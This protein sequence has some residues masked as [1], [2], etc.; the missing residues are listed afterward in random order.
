M[1]Y[2]YGLGAVVLTMEPTRYEHGEGYE[3]GDS[4]RQLLDQGPGLLT[5]QT[6]LRTPFVW[7]QVRPPNSLPSRS[8]RRSLIDRIR[9]R[10]QNKS[11]HVAALFQSRFSA[12]CHRWLNE[13]LPAHRQKLVPNS[14]TYLATHACSF[15]LLISYFRNVSERLL[16]V[17]CLDC[18]VS[19]ADIEAFIDSI[20]SVS[21]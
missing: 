15:L 3:L 2:K 6:M 21:L 11:S 13:P 18:P 14:T 9:R 12:E 10:N 4:L 5:R 19:I 7:I 1:F 17:E 8:F 20:Q 16:R